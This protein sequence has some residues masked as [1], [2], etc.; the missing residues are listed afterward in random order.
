MKKNLLAL[1]LGYG[2][3]AASALS[4]SATARPRWMA[5]EAE[6]QA[7]NLSQIDSLR[8]LVRIS[9]PR[10]Q[11]TRLRFVSYPGNQLLYE[12]YSRQPTCGQQLNLS[13]LADGTYGVEVSIGTVQYC[14]TLQL[15]STTRRQAQLKAA[16]RPPLA[17]R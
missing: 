6:A 2:L 13:Q 10:Q 14:Y 16:L 15:Q 11:A 9:N 7:V 12:T 3:L 4:R 17:R 1:L 5:A 8:Y